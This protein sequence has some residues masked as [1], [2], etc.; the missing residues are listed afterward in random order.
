MAVERFDVVVVGAGSAGAALAARLSEDP[1]RRVLLLE[2]G[3]DHRS[4]DAPAGVAGANFFAA[5]ETTGRLW[6]DLMAERAPGRPPTLYARGRGVGGSSSINALMAI[7]GTP[8]DYDRW[9][10]DLGCPGWSWS[11]LLPWFL[12][13]EDDVD[14]GGDGLH[15]KGGTIPLLRTPLDEL[16]PLDLAVRAALA[17]LGYPATDDYHA[18]GATGV[19]PA[20]RSRCATGAGSPRTT[21]T[22]SRPGPVPTSSYGGTSWST[23]WP[24]KATGPSVS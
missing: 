4:A 13:V 12:T 7:R 9:A 2:A 22:W 1:A 3:P 8:E 20:S 19:E 16:S 17:D 18:P 21:P 24:W 15:G 23:G 5:L 10:Y 14:Y 11:E 6:P